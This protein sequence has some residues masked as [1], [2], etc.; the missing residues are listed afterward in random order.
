MQL[1]LKHIYSG[2]V[3]PS[4]M[5]SSKVIMA[6]ADLATVRPRCAKNLDGTHKQDKAM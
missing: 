3:S 5:K 6:T 2:D 1:V 4:R